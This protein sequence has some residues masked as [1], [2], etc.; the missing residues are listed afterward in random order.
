MLSV[1]VEAVQVSVVDVVMSSMSIPLQLLVK[2]RP[3]PVGK[4]TLMVEFSP[5]SVTSAFF[6]VK[7]AV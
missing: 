2:L 7:L 3:V 5:L 4:V 1:G 6:E